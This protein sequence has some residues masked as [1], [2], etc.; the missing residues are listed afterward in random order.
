MMQEELYLL[1][2]R[3]GV[4]PY[5]WNGIML[6]GALFLGNQVV[7]GGALLRIIAAG[8]LV[9][10]FA[11]PAIEQPKRAMY[12]L[13]AWLPFLGIVRRAL[14]PAT[15]FTSL[16]PLLLVS[17]AVIILIFLT[18]LISGKA[19]LDGTWLS[20][21]VFYLLLIGILQVF[22]PAQ[23]NLL[24]GLTGVMFV[25][26]P[27]VCFFIGRSVADAKTINKMLKW[28]IGAGAIAA[29]YGMYQVVVGF[30]GFEKA[31]LDRAGFGGLYVGTAIRP[32]STFTNPLEYATYLNFAVM[33]TLAFVLYRKGVRR[34]WLVG[35]LAI[36][37]YA[38]YMIGSR[39]FIVYAVLGSI[40]LIA[41]RAKSMLMTFAL[42]VLMLGGIVYWTSTNNG[43]TTKLDETKTAQQQLEQR[44][45]IGLAD[46]L[47]PNKSTLRQHFSGVL[48]GLK[49]AATEQPF[50]LGTGSTGRGSSKFGGAG[51]NSTELDISDAAVAFGVI[52]G[53]I[54]IAIIIIAGL[55]LYRMRRII[56][57][58][59]IPAI[60]GMAIVSFGQW[61]NGGN[62][63]VAPLIWF[64]LG[65]ADAAILRARRQQ[66][67]GLGV[68]D[69]PDRSGNAMVGDD[70]TIESLPA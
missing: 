59:M 50:G 10:A 70:M 8:S 38:G 35:L 6:I 33:T 57:G 51:S 37:V 62:Y 3:P 28:I 5:L 43:T 16:D 63:A 4:R 44:N 32:F 25:L 36:M 13:F 11:I 69:L 7:H 24:V 55:Q 27:M 48:D 39:G 56:P 60:L 52:G 45:A 47:D 18:L 9:L 66:A 20:R 61:L 46:P 41:S 17:S 23:G 40:A 67:L 58:P 53:A 31:Y 42:L 30:P 14:V 22:N 15:G 26:V 65:A 34:Y 19:N 54:Y 64:M 2:D 49:F 12:M 68:S 1:E 21:L 29:L